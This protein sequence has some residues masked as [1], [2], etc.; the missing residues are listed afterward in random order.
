MT[1]LT[2]SQRWIWC[3]EAHQTSC[4]HVVTNQHGGM[5]REEPRSLVMFLNPW[6][7]YTQTSCYERI[8][9]LLTCFVFYELDFL[10]LTFEW[11]PQWF[12]WLFWWQI[13]ICI[14]VLNHGLCTPA[15]SQGLYLIHSSHFPNCK[16]NAWVLYGVILLPVGMADPRVANH[17]SASE[18]QPE[19][20]HSDWEREGLEFR[21]RNLESRTERMRELSRGSQRGFGAGAYHMDH[22][23]TE[24]TRKLVRGRGSEK[25]RKRYL[26]EEQSKWYLGGSWE[27]PIPDYVNPCHE[28][29]PPWGN[30][31]EPLSLSSDKL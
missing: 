8:N 5:A 28:S 26:K 4:D 7:A 13:L 17:R 24:V 9:K 29:P 20:R 12:N 2:P 23:Q 19:A 21:F 1:I 16:R 11:I 18:L 31:S 30:K 27:V 6:V 10:L 22:E 3:P 15:T 25:G 14:S